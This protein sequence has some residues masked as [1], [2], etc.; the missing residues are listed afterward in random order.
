MPILDPIKRRLSLIDDHFALKAS[1]SEYFLLPSPF[2]ILATGFI[3][4]LIVQHH[5]N[6]PVIFAAITL[7]L[8]SSAVLFRKYVIPNSKTA[9][10][11]LFTFLAFTSLGF[12]RLAAHSRPAP[13]DIRNLV[14]GRT[15][16]KIRGTIST[17]PKIETRDQWLFA[18]YVWTDP[19]T[20]FYMDLEQTNTN[21]GWQDVKGTIRVQIA[22]PVKDIA[23]G[24]LLQIHCWLDTFQPPSNPGQF[25]IT[26]YLATRN[27]FVAANV[28]SAR[29]INI[30]SKAPTNSFTSVK[31]K[32]KIFAT[33]ALVG[34]DIPQNSTS[35]LLPALILGQRDYSSATFQAFQKTGLAHFICL[36]GMHMGIL[37]GFVWYLCR[38][39][40]LPKP[41]RA[42]ISIAIIFLY[43]MVVPP[44]AATLRAAIICISFFLSII[45]R[46]K[47]NPLNSLSFSAVALLLI[48][49]MDLFS[50][51]FQLSYATVLGILL[52]YSHISDFL[53]AFTL[54][55]T[56]LY[57]NFF[58]QR[59]N[60]PYFLKKLLLGSMD[61]L[62]VG[63]SA[64]LGGAG[65]LLYHFGII[66]PLSAL[67]T[68]LVFPLVLLVLVTGFT[69]L[70]LAAIFPTLSVIVGAAANW[71]SDLLA[72][73][74]RL[75]ASFDSSQFTI[76][77]TSLLFV[78][79]YYLVLLFIR[80]V[81]L[82]PPAKKS[83][84]ALMLTVLFFSLGFTKHIKTP[85]GQL[86]LTCL[87]VGHGQ[88]VVLTLPSKKHILF[89]TGSISTKN[90]GQRVVLPFLS[91]QGIDKLDAVVISHDDID[92]I[93]GLPE[94]VT[95]FSETTV[96]ANA[97][98]IQQTKSRSSAA[99]LADHLKELNIDLMPI[100]LLSDI[101]QQV[102]ITP[103][104]PTDNICADPAISDNDKSL[105]CLIEYANK[106]ILLCSDIE[107]LAQ[108]SI[109]EKHP[110]LTVD[111]LLM[112]HHGSI[113][114]LQNSFVSSLN[115]KTVIISCSKKRAPS[116]FKPPENITSFYT[117][118]NGAVTVKIKADGNIVTTGF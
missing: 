73:L 20:I 85:P 27:V 76:G 110:D 66:T 39:T 43:M 78:L 30:L 51:G 49:P 70:L 55:K 113:R 36:S 90:T 37:A 8:C 57:D 12:I 79:F 111:V 26:K 46:Q 6:I 4:G 89:D 67:W 34:T 115:P 2:F 106:K 68:M 116:A 56:A 75:I 40:G 74:V 93:N 11:V 87:N 5:F 32:L 15:L 13:N 96:Y 60:L 23:T 47:P 17:T 91:Y 31:N 54:D 83:A 114:N 64:W 16:A 117:P 1:L 52:F 118:I 53:M 72:F 61:L 97:A 104:W 84:T 107:Q 21:H 42:L 80:F 77:K 65:I 22:E 109:I 18:K 38:F 45:I 48:R 25:D 50:P 82:K 88:A 59:R 81:D 19:A 28:V 71:I 100:D 10:L 103:L 9:L 102:S 58:V 7:L 86:T 69:K 41:I 63:I 3:T 94:V 92:H 95:R 101:P 24:D 29:S 99:F 108:N 62:C 14:A 44:R 105:V 112:P 33:E 35:T 98:F